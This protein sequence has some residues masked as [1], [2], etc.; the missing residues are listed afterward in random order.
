M[1]ARTK[2]GPSSKR[3]GFAEPYPKTSTGNRNV[4]G[5]PDG[6]YNPGYNTFLPY[7]NL[8]CLRLAPLA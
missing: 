6:L 2:A 4:P 7:R 1:A 8:L 5:A 3:S